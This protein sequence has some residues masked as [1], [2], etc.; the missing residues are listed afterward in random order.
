MNEALIL[1]GALLIGILLGAFFFGGLWWTIRIGP[2]SE[3]TG[4]LFSGS[5]LL[6]VGVA[7]AGF[8]LVSR[9]DWRRL[10]ACLVGFLIARVAITQFI[11]VTA[12]NNSRII[13]EG[14]Q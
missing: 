2:P 6:R 11:R 10:V 5:F 8:Y 3:W 1:V 13:E 4:L 12:E 9:G 7:V 14:G